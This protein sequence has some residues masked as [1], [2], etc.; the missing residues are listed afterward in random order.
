VSHAAHNTLSWIFHG[1]R[2]YAATDKSLKTILSSIGLDAASDEGKEAI[3]I[4]REAARTA[5][6]K[7]ADD[8]INDFFDYAYGPPIPG[9]YQPTPGGSPLP[10]TPQAQFV[11]LFAAV[12]DVTQ[13]SLPP[14]PNP[15]TDPKYQDY[16]LYVKN[17]GEANS[18][19]RKPYDTDTAYFW[20][21]SS[22][23]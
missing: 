8:G 7:R 12:G 2:N 4:G 22:P 17:Q 21:E 1:T 14:P 5:I 9:E 18:T 11:K 15:T 19:I 13:F 3:K 16:L 6:S 10:D 23:T 20:R